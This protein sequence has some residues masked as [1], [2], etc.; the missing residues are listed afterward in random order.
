MR[1]TSYSVYKPRD[2]GR[3]ITAKVDAAVQ[4]AVIQW[5]EKVLAV[6]QSIVPVDTGELRASGH[7]VVRTD[8]SKAAAAVVFDAPYAVY[9]EFGTGARG[10]GS[11]GAGPGPYSLGWTGMAAQPYLRP[12]FD[13][14]KNEAPS[15]TAATVTAGLG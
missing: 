12:A 8:A 7:V 2:N 11:P 9:V 14:L 1:L 3:F 6:A 15:M 10:E 13:E 5:A 4:T